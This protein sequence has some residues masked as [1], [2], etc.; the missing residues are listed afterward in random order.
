MS[1][2]RCI[3][4]LGVIIYFGYG[5]APKEILVSY[6]GL[7]IRDWV[8]DFKYSVLFVSCLSDFI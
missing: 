1:I 4:P 5:L 2:I 7:K 6:S 8:F 3:E